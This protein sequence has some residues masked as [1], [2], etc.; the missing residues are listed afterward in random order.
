M[1]MN[2]SDRQTFLQTS[3][4]RIGQQNHGEFTNIYY[5]SEI[6]RNFANIFKGTGHQKQTKIFR[7]RLQNLIL[8]L[9]FLIFLINFQSDVR[10]YLMFVTLAP[11][12][13]T[14]D[15]IDNIEQKK[16][17]KSTAYDI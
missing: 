14:N 6:C 11:E 1:T 8:L 2:L 5:T 16:D 13:N 17:Y 7:N 12:L 4:L 15:K 3:S 10:Q 9:R